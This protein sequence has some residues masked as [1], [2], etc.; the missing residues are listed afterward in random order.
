MQMLSKD[1]G[2]TECQTLFAE[3]TIK[4]TLN[5][6]SAEFALSV[7]TAKLNN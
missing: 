1:T 5:L 3:K 2:G 4:K 7:L 6:L